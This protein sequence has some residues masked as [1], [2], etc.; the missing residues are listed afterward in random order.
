MNSPPSYVFPDS[1]ETL[2]AAYGAK[3]KGMVK[4]VRNREQK[5]CDQL[6]TN[7]QFLLLKPAERMVPP[8][9]FELGLDH[10]H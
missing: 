2:A 10:P 6:V 4:Q 8:T 7:W 5:I 9:G 1:Q 3:F